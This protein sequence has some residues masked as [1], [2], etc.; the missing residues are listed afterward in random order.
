MADTPQPPDP[1]A[2]EITLLLQRA[3]AGDRQAADRIFP[4]V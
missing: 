4:L 3:S 1:F 2:G